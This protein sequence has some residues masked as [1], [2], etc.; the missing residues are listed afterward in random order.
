MAGNDIFLDLKGIPGEAKDVVFHDKIDLDSYSFSCHVPRDVATM[1]TI[2]KVQMAP[3]TCVKHA[4]K[5][6][7]PLLQAM[8]TNKKIDTAEVIVRKAG[9]RGQDYLH[10]KLEDVYVTSYSTSA[11]TGQETPMPLETFQLVFGKITVQY[12]EQ[13]ERGGLGGPLVAIQDLRSPQ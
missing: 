3:L 12:A 13:T 2:G 11:A 5:A 10:I 4:D 1:Q 9:G 8:W 7:S 6:T